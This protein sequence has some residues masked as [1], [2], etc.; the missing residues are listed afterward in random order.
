MPT[1]NF[2]H[3]AS[4]PIDRKSITDTL[5]ALRDAEDFHDRSP[6]ACI[7]MC[8]AALETLASGFAKWLALGDRTSMSFK[9]EDGLNS[10]IHHY[11]GLGLVKH[12]QVWRELQ[13]KKGFWNR[14]V[15]RNEVLGSDAAI[16]ELQFFHD[17]SWRM[18]SFHGD[19]KAG[20]AN[21]PVFV[22]RPGIWSQ[23]EGERAARQLGAQR[24]SEL[25]A[26]LNQHKERAS[27]QTASEQ[28]ITAELKRAY[29][30]LE[31]AE[32]R[33]KSLAARREESPASPELQKMLLASEK[34]AAELVA[35]SLG[36]E[37]ELKAAREEGDSMRAHARVLE[38]ALD[39]VR[40]EM[41]RTLTAQ[42][43]LEDEEHRRLRYDREYPGLEWAHEFF[44]ASIA[45]DDRGAL[46]PL[47]GL[48]GA[49]A[50]SSDPY[51]SRFES[52]FRG[53]SCT[54]RVIRA[55]DGVSADERCRA[56]EIEASNL[57]KMA[58]FRG[59]PGIAVLL[60]GC[61]ED[62]PGFALFER[63]AIRVLSLYGS[64]GSAVRLSAALR[65]TDALLSDFSARASAR[66]SVSWPDLD[67]V[68]VRESGP[69]LLE[70]SAPHAGDLG[71]PE[72]IGRSAEQCRQMTR[73]EL[74]RGWTYALAHACLRL[75]ACIP[76]AHSAC[77]PK[78]HIA[79]AH[80]LSILEEGRRRCDEPLS[81]ERVRALAPVLIAAMH[82][83]PHRRPLLEQLVHAL[84]APLN[85][86]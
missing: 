28:A 20:V 22:V 58:H 86:P 79:E 80:L 39:S 52:V 49:I 69:I 38:Q 43:Q 8:R 24:L 74:E 55:H 23:L 34:R 30:D 46:P 2:A 3:L 51:S 72:W 17:V 67:A 25:E 84:R 4:L 73:E 85:H 66:M 6:H 64:G 11:D 13:R 61:S 63:P 16:K 27:A 83:E 50:L 19:P 47:D 57:S 21:V 10:I 33:V 53:A 35:R 44:D 29:Q 40:V 12:A 18:C 7:C 32:A 45:G 77:A 5:V 71:P 14:I 42:R 36:L 70:P 76:T 56:W 82:V 68:G 41:V 65:F 59:K 54:L 37:G 31:E 81:L 26:Q 9:L 75:A 1:D 48:N 60:S 62:K 15:H 78:I